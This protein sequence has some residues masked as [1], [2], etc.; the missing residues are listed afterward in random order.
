MQNGSY[1]FEQY[2][3]KVLKEFKPYP[4]K[5]KEGSKIERFE[6]AFSALYDKKMIEKE[7]LYYNFIERELIKKE[8]S[9]SKEYKH[10]DGSVEGRASSRLWY[11]M[12]PAVA[13]PAFMAH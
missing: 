1:D 9:K 12:P 13:R 11:A 3:K 6:E 10:N 4:V 8:G 7:I 2:E 5:T